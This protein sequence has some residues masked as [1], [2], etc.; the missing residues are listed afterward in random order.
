[1]D[2]AITAHAYPLPVWSPGEVVVD[3]AQMSTANMIAAAMQF[4]RVCTRRRLRCAVSA[5]R[6]RVWF[7]RIAPG[8]LKF[9]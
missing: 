6:R 3:H 4:G 5:Q 9:R 1:V 8:C 2:Q 7:L